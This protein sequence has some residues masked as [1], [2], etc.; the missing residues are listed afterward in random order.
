[1]PWESGLKDLLYSNFCLEAYNVIYHILMHKKCEA[2]FTA[3]ARN[4]DIESLVAVANLTITRCGGGVEIQ[5]CDEL[6]NAEFCKVV[7]TRLKEAGEL[8][9]I[10]DIK[11]YYLYTFEVDP[12]LAVICAIQQGDIE[13]FLAMDNGEDN[14]ASLCSVGQYIFSE[15][16]VECTQLIHI[17]CEA[18]SSQAFAEFMRLYGSNSEGDSEGDS[19]MSQCLSWD[20]PD[21]VIIL[22]GSDL[23]DYV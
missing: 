9:K 2:M 13:G 8:S 7:L 20:G 12:D 17:I 14:P 23:E 21:E 15:A 18:V 16:C 5:I 6:K 4:C 19:E 11:R 10:V 22:G 3:I 1:M